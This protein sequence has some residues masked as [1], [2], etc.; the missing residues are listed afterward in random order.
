MKLIIF[1]DLDATLLDPVNYS[2]EAASQAIDALKERQA[3]IVLVSS[4]TLAEI[5]PLHR[6]LDLADPFIVENG[7]G[8]ALKAESTLTHELQKKKLFSKVRNHGEYLL[9]ALG[10]EYPELVARLGE[11]SSELA[12][13]LVG[14]SSM[15]AA[16]V[17]GLTGLSPGQAVNAKDRLFDEPF[18]LPVQAKGRESEVREAAA[19]KGLT[20]VEG[21]RFWH[22]IGHSG[23]GRVVSILI[24]SYRRSY[25]EIHTVGLGDSPNDFSFLELVD[26]AVL[27]GG[28]ARRSSIPKNLLNARLTSVSGP[29]G[30]NEE[31]LSVLGEFEAL[32]VGS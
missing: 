8:I 19:R 2:W 17:A 30:W 6:E 20:A 27:L 15:S 26:T 3:S 16:E 23:K 25:G 14:F 11:I 5:A 7:G 18:L 32:G 12:L 1:T 31:V 10:T 28:A 22:L 4:K 9:I 24:Q 29:Q 13:P 21:G